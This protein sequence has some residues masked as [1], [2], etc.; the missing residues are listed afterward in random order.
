MTPAKIKTHLDRLD[1]LEKSGHLSTGFYDKARNYIISEEMNQAYSKKLYFNS[2]QNV[3]PFVES[4]SC[5]NF[6]SYRIA[7]YNYVLLY[8]KEKSIL[9]PDFGLL[10]EAADHLFTGETKK[11]ALFQ[12]LNSKMNTDLNQPGYI[13]AIKKFSDSYPGDDLTR[14]LNN[15]YSKKVEI[16]KSITSDIYNERLIDKGNNLIT[17]SG[18]LNKFPDKIVILDFWAQY[19]VPC[20]NEIPFSKKMADDLQNE[21]VVFIYISLDINY[22]SWLENIARL[23]I[24][25]ED[26]S[27]LMYLPVKSGIMEHFDIKSI[28]RYIVFGRDR[29]LISMDAPRPSDKALYDLI[30]GNLK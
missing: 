19:C 15:V 23:G 27:Y 20:L 10:A 14:F 7:A 9:K 25:F 12:L 1:S 18:I 11:V 21:D 24:G 3:K 8:L 17:F 29:K 22:E 16:L 4:D 6:L 28:P 30:K 2:N 5:V 13:Q 26:R